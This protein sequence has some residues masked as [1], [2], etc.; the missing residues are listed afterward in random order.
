MH[1]EMYHWGVKGM[2]W[3]V[4]RYQR[5]DG[6]LTAAGK[7]R[8][9]KELEKQR[10]EAETVEQK[11][12]RILKSRSAKDL[13]ENAHLF[14]DKELNT[15]YNRLNLERN[16]K[17]LAPEEVSRGKSF[18]DGTIRTLETTKKLMDAGTSAYISAQRVAKL[19]DK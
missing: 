8:Q 13:Y 18:I 6:S 4:R 1:D 14:D 3:G 10:K 16:I 7:K 12:E 19:F 17:N 11:K 2:R 15:A 9:A 5:K